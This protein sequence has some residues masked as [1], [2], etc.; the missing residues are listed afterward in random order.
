MCHVTLVSYIVVPQESSLLERL[1]QGGENFHSLPNVD[2]C[3]ATQ[4]R[5]QCHDNRAWM[6]LP[7]PDT[8]TTHM[9]M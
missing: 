9:S 1:K 3:A 7:G 4:Q 2:F 8:A 5:P 6:G